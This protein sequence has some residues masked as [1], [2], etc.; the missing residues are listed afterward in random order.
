M[1]D[2][3]I[4]DL[5]SKPQSGGDLP[6][7]VGKQYGSGW[8][9]TLFRFAFPVIK[10]LGSMLGNVAT[11]TTTEYLNKDNVNIGDTIKSN[12]INEAK[13]VIP[14]VIGDTLSNATENVIKKKRKKSMNKRKLSSMGTIFK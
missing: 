11:K 1:N 8:L 12:V 4:V 13:T 14:E 10:K 5:Y 9:K 3:I 2:P 6:Y 7:F